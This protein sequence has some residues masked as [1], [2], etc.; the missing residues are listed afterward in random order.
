[1]RRS[2]NRSSPRKKILRQQLSFARQLSKM[3]SQIEALKAS[4]A[5]AGEAR[6]SQLSEQQKA[7]HHA[8]F[9]TNAGDPRLPRARF[10]VF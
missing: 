5:K 1:M 3:Q 8:A 7:L 10:S 4:L 6:Y 2:S 9:V